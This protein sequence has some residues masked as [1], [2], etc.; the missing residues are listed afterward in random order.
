MV[1]GGEGKMSHFRY[2]YEKYKIFSKNRYVH[3]GIQRSIPVPVHTTLDQ[4]E[5]SVQADCSI[6]VLCES[7]KKQELLAAFYYLYS[8]IR[9]Q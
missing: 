5:R 1:T 7:S 4:Q 3:K 6:P 9:H 8:R 2:H